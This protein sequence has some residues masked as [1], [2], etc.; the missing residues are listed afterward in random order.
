MKILRE[1]CN[2]IVI[3]ANIYTPIHT[4]PLRHPNVVKHVYKDVGRA[5]VEKGSTAI[6][7]EENCL[8]IPKL[9]LSQTLTLTVGK[10]FSDAIVCSPPN[11][12]TN[13]DLD[14][15]ANPNQGAI[16][17]VGQLSGYPWEAVSQYSREL[18]ECYLHC[19]C[20]SKISKSYSNGIFTL[21]EMHR[22]MSYQRKS[23]KLKITELWHRYM[24]KMYHAIY[25]DN[26]CIVYI[27][28]FGKWSIQ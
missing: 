10:N 4:R 17:I 19:L 2:L 26:K 7:P 1:L 5:F 24:S 15:N 28:F 3:L 14:P 8:P 13:P 25:L 11:T 16:F 18:C 6:A 23:H 22:S 20:F 21:T 27:I 9:T 12:K